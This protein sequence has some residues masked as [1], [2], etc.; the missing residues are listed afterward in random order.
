MSFKD[1]ALKRAFSIELTVLAVTHICL[2]Q[3]QQRQELIKSIALK[4]ADRY[5]AW[6]SG[7]TQQLAHSSE[8]LAAKRM[9]IG[10]NDG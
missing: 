1:L 4:S 6:E 5:R 3:K 2:R 9:Q 10:Q 7:T 8:K